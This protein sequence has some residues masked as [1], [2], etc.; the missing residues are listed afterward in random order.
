MT[1]IENYLKKHNLEEVL[2]E[3]GRIDLKILPYIKDIE[4]GFFVEAGAL[5]GVFMSNTKLLEDLG[6]TGILIEPSYLAWQK[7]TK[8]RKAISEHCALVSK[9]YDQPTIMGNFLYDGEDGKGAWSTICR[10]NPDTLNVPVKAK[11]LA[12]ILKKHHIKKVDLL[13]LDVEGYELEVLKGIDFG[14]VDIRNILIEINIDQYHPEEV[15]KL[16]EPW[17]FKNYG[18]LSNF[19]KETNAGWPGWHQDYL[20]KK[21]I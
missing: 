17:G 15:D 5:D 9:D 8:N 1:A 3:P 20:F 10:D 21:I 19:S 13:S 16:L 18:C 2:K 11:T 4:N 14:A 12:S 6:W 7:C